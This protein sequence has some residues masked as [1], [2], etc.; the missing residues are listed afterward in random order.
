MLA[1]SLISVYLLGVAPM[2][3]AQDKSVRPGVNDTFKDPD[4]KQF[5]ERF[6]TESREIYA[7]RK[8]ILAACKVTPGM[9]VADVG[10]GTG[11]FTRAFAQAVGKEGSVIA[12]DISKTFLDHIAKS[13]RDEGMTQVMTVEATAE[14]SNLPAD[15]VDLVFICDTYHHFEFPIKTMQSI[16]KALKQGGR[17]VMIDFKRI[18]GESTEWVMS[19]VRAGQEVFESEVEQSGFRKVG[20]IDDVLKENYLLVFEKK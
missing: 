5:Q 13:S 20:Q 19:H 1:G 12:V 2:A 4:L 11:L 14:S 9:S 7:K 3:M 18:E 17:V 10:A 8:E 15:S 16:Q 6:E